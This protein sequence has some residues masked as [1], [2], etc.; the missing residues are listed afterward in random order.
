M[1][2]KSTEKFDYD[3][4][5]INDIKRINLHLHTNVSDESLSPKTWLISSEIGLDLISKPI[6]NTADLMPNPE[7]CFALEDLLVWK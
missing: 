5:E 6:M 3:S 4:K 1:Q 2:N 7:K